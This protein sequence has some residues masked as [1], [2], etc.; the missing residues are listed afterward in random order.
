[1]L[2]V[3]V[4]VSAAYAQQSIESYDSLFEGKEK[5]EAG[6]YDSLSAE[7]Y[8]R[9]SKDIS[10]L[11]ATQF[12]LERFR[13]GLLE[14]LGKTP[15]LVPDLGGS[16]SEMSP[17]K[18]GFYFGSVA[19]WLLLFFFIGYL[20]ETQI[21]GRR[22]VGPW[23]VS[24]Q[25]E[26]PEGIS[27][28]LPILTIRALLGFVGILIT[29]LIVGMLTAAFL[30]LSDPATQKTV[31]VVVPSIAIIRISANIW[32]TIL[33]PYLSQY[34]L[35]ALSDYDAKKL[36]NWL[37]VTVTV[38][39]VLIAFTYW[40][41]DLGANEAPHA[42]VT[43]VAAI[44]IMVLNVAMIVA[45]SRAISQAILG[46]RTWSSATWL[47]KTGSTLW[48]PVAILYMILLANRRSLVLTSLC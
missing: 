9:V 30:D 37:W 10:V 15:Q 25:V 23:Y 11:S 2:L 32:R 22:I 20:I 16:I 44:V 45:N 39:V 14:L 7:D 47:A 40:L 4:G 41:R 17:T 42:L 46:D 31:L 19:L 1:M 5:D 35:S 48:A 24:L 12:S 3:L 21:Y 27:E 38:S 8:E 33:S 13:S 36:F 43:L 6:L 28:K 29:L 26:K 18:S 34:R